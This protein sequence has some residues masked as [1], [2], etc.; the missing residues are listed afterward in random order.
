MFNE[1]GERIGFRYTVIYD[2]YLFEG[3]STGTNRMDTDHW[4]DVQGMINAYGEWIT[5]KDNEY[6]LT[7]EKGEWF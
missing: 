1:D 3:D 6:D 7:W 5:V 2:G 4:E